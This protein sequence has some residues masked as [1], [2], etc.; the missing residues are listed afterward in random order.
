MMSRTTEVLGKAVITSISGT[1]FFGKIRSLTRSL[2]DLKESAQGKL[3]L[4]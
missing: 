2:Q 4:L 1:N 3:G